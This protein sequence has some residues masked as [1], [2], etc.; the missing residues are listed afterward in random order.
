LRLISSQGAQLSRFFT[1][2]VLP[3]DSSIPNDMIYKEG[4]S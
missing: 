3:E 1:F 4:Q 2:G